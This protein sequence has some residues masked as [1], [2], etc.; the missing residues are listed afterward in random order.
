[1]SQGTVID[2]SAVHFRFALGNF[3]VKIKPFAQEKIGETE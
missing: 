1:M 3:K 2:R